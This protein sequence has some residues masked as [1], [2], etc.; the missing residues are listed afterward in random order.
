MLLS[1]RSDRTCYSYVPYVLPALAPSCDGDDARL[2]AVI[3][4]ASQLRTVRPKVRGSSS[5]STVFVSPADDV[6]LFHQ[7]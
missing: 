7:R 3:A 6:Q 2:E 5:R 1:N 4:S